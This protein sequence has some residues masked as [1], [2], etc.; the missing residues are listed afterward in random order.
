M[1]MSRAS[2]TALTMICVHEG[3]GGGVSWDTAHD[4]K[5]FNDPFMAAASFVILETL[6]RIARAAELIDFEAQGH[7]RR[8][9]PKAQRATHRMRIPPTV[10]KQPSKKL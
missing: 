6:N 8:F 3:E 5:T 10:L 7:G 9:G 1:F 2:A 4:P